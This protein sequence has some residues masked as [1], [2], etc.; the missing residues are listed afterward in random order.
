MNDAAM[1]IEIPFPRDI[2][3]TVFSAIQCVQ[4]TGEVPSFRL[5]EIASVLP[6]VLFLGFQAFL[7]GLPH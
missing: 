3:Q 2:V 7:D 4:E 1:E 5:K 6:C